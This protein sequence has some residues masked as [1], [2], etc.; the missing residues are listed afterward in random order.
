MKSCANEAQRRL[1]LMTQSLN[2]SNARSIMVN[3]VEAFNLLILPLK[4][5]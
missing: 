3:V 4:P 2:R 1:G 5:L